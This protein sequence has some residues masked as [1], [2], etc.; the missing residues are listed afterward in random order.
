MN[1]CE[2]LLGRSLLLETETYASLVL[3][4][5]VQE[6]TG[7]NGQNDEAAVGDLHK[8]CDEGGK[9]KAFDDERSEVGDAA[10]RDVANNT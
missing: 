3:E 7:Q 5:V 9:A 1:S 8:C 2:V 6:D 10:I 4:T